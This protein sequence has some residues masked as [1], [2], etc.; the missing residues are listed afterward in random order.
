MQKI[1]LFLLLM[2]CVSFLRAQ[3]SPS[4]TGNNTYNYKSETMSVSG[5][6]G[7]GYLNTT[8]TLS[9]SG[10]EFHIGFPYRFV[11]TQDA[12]KGDL[13]VS[14]GYYSNYIRLQWEI[15]DPEVV[16]Q[17]KIYR[18]LL[19]EAD[20][21]FSLAATVSSQE[22][23]WQDQYAEPGLMYEYKVLADGI[24]DTEII[25]INRV[26]GVGFRVTSATIT[27]RVTYA[28]GNVVPGVKIIAEPE[29]ENKEGEFSYNFPG[30][31]YALV[32][33]ENQ[34]NL[35]EGAS[36]QAWVKPTIKE[37]QSDYPIFSIG[38]SLSLGIKHSD[39]NNFVQVQMG[40]DIKLSEAI[41]DSIFNEF[42]QLSLT[43]N[44]KSKECLI[45]LNGDSLLHSSF[46]SG[47]VA[48]ANWL[49][50]GSIK[51]ENYNYYSGYLDEVKLWSKTLSNK[52][53]FSTFDSYQNPNNASLAGYWKFNEGGGNNIY[54]ISRTGNNFN[55]NHGLIVKHGSEY[56]TYEE[57]YP[58]TER[59]GYKAVT[60]EN[61]NY[62]IAGVAFSSGG[63]YF[64][65]VPSLGVHRFDPTNKLL[66]ISQESSVF[67]NIDFTDE[68]SFTVTGKIFYK[69]TK[70]PVSDVY[71][72]V[73]GS[74]VSDSK[75]QPI[76]TDENGEYTIDVPIGLH[77]ISVEKNGHVFESAYWPAMDENENPTYFDF[78]DDLNGRDFSDTTKIKL[79]GKIVG[80]PIQG[81]KATG[82]K[83]E[84]TKANIGVVNVTLTTERGFEL[85]DDN[86]DVSFKTD[87]TT[88]VYE[89]ELIPEKFILKN[90][91]SV[92]N[93]HYTF[94]R[95]EDKTTID[96]SNKFTL[97]YTIDSVCVDSLVEDE[98][99]KFFD[100]VDT[101]LVYNHNRD[102][103]WRETPKL[104]VQ[105]SDKVAFWGDSVYTITNVDETTTD[106]KLVEFNETTEEYEYTFNYPIFK[107][108]QYYD[109]TVK[110]TETYIN[111]DD[112]EN[113]VYDNVPVTDGV[114]LV[115]NQLANSNKS[116]RIELNENGKAVHSFCGGMP[117]ESSPFTQNINFKLKINDAFITGADL[118]QACYL[119]GIKPSGGTNFVTG[120]DE[121]DFILRDPPGSNSYSYFE[122]GFT[123]SNTKTESHTNGF[124]GDVDVL[125]L[126]G[127]EL[128]TNVGGLGF[129]IQNKIES[130]NSIGA[131]TSNE[132]MWNKD[133][134]QTTSKTYQF[135]FSTS[136]D[137]A[138]VGSMGD[139]YFGHG[140]NIF[141]GAA[142]GVKIIPDDAGV[143]FDGQ[144]YSIG[145]KKS[146]YTG[147]SS[148][149]EF[150]YT[151]NHIENYLIPNLIELRNA[152]F[153]GVKYIS[154]LDEN[155]ERYGLS[156]DDPIFEGASVD[157]TDTFIDGVSYTFTPDGENY[158]DS[159]YFY[160]EIINN[161]KQQ[162]A[163]N[164]ELK[165]TAVSDDDPNNKHT[166]ISFDAGAIVESAVTTDTSDVFTSTYDWSIDAGVAAD[167]G[168]TVNGF[169]MKVS[170]TERYHKGGTSSN[171]TEETS[172]ETI[173]FV[174]AD[175][176]QGD[177]FSLD[178]KK[179]TWV[180]APV[181]VLRGGQSSCPFEGIEKT[182]YFE[183][184]EHV[185][186]N[187]TMQIE[188]PV[189][190]AEISTVTNVPENLAAVFTLKMSNVSEVGADGWYG[191][192]VDAASNPDGAV[193]K[194][195]GSNLTNG[196]SVLIPAGQ[197][198]SK[199]ITVE[200]GKAE[201]NDYENL[202]IIMHSLCQFDPTD[203]VDDIADTAT[204]SAYFIP[205]CTKV[206]LA[207]PLDQWTV[208]VENNNELPIKIDGYDV[209]H[210]TFEDFMFQY[211]PSESSSWI[212]VKTFVNHPIEEGDVD[213]IDIN[214][215]PTISYVWDMSSLQNRE[216]D[217]RVISHCIDGST[218]E[219]DVVSGIFDNKRPELFGTPQPADGILSSNDEIML[220]FDEDIQAGLISKANISVTGIENN[221]DLRDFDFLQHNASLHFDGISQNMT[222]AQDINLKYSPFTF[223][224]WAKRERTGK[225]CIIA[226]GDTQDGGLWI[227]FDD[228][229]HF[230]MTINGQDISTTE[231]F[232]TTDIYNH[233]ACVFNNNN[234]SGEIE[235]MLI[236]ASG[237][238]TAIATKILTSNY[239][240]NAPLSVGYCTYDDSA[241]K[242]NIHDLRIWN[243][244]STSSEV[245]ARR[246]TI[247][248]GYE[249]GLIGAWPMDDMQG[250]LAKDIA[251]SRHGQ[252]NATWHTNSKGFGLALNG[253]YAVLN[254]SQLELSSNADFTIE[255]WFKS[256]I[257]SSDEYIL[258]N[259]K[260]DGSDNSELKWA[261]VAS[262]DNTIKILNDGSE[263]I[264]SG[265]D[266]LDN[267]WHH[268]AM[269]I[270]RHGNMDVY[271]D[272]SSK[273]TTSS[274]NVTGF[275]GSKCVLGARYWLDVTVEHFDANFN[276]NIDEAR[277]WNG[278]R[279]QDLIQNY[280]H[281]SLR[282]N[283]FGLKAYYPFED[284]T[285]TDP[286]MSTSTGNNMTL[287]ENGIAGECT[288]IGSASFSD[289]TAA[290]KLTRPVSEI[291]FSFTTNGN[292]ILISPTIDA[293]R[294]E[295]TTLDIAVNSIY[296]L[297]GN[298][299]ESTAAWSA[300]VDKNQ[301]VWEKQSVTLST[302]P[303][304][305]L[306]FKM[307]IYNQSG[308]KEYWQIDNLPVWL[309][310]DMEQGTLDPLSSQ[311]I[312][313]SVNPAV[314]VGQYSHDIYL[315]GSMDF[316]ERCTINL[317][318]KDKEPEWSVNPSDYETSM[319]LIGKLKIAGEF[320]TDESDMVG[321]FINNECRGVAKVKYFSDQNIYLV[322][323]T[324]HGESDEVSQVNLRVWDASKG[325]LYTNINTSNSLQESFDLKFK[326]NDIIGLP[327]APTLIET[328][329][330][331]GIEIPIKAGWNWLSF[332]LVSDQLDNTNALLAGVC[333]ETDDEIKFNEDP[334]GQGI[335]DEY[336]SPYGW[337]GALST[338]GFD[339]S[340]MY[341]L[342][343]SYADTIQLSGNPVLTA[344][345]PISINQG[346]N[347]IGYTPQ[348]KMPVKSALAY[349]SP[350]QNDLVKSQS[351]FAMYDD[352]LG[353]IGSL[354]YMEPN[355][356]YMYYSAN[357]NS[358]TFVYP[359]ETLFTKSA[360]IN[361]G[362]QSGVSFVDL[363]YE[364]NMSALIEVYNTPVKN[365]A[366]SRLLAI[367]DGKI[368]GQ[369][370]P[371]IVG[372]KYI[373]P[374][375]IS[376]PSEDKALSFQLIDSDSESVFTAKEEDTYR[377]NEILGSVNN[378][379]A[380]TF[381][382]NADE[383]KPLL[384]APN[385]FD[386]FT[387]ITNIPSDVTKIVLY[388]IKGQI[389]RQWS[390]TESGEIL[391]DCTSYNKINVQSGIYL[392]KVYGINGYQQI[393]IVKL[394]N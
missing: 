131:S 35:S 345:Y 38:T 167:L 143:V 196:M 202:H 389:I 352:M 9:N 24:W 85:W 165:V 37:G 249:K 139:V 314:N 154:K 63:S 127:V 255:F 367:V 347:W 331:I 225:E 54:D 322:N 7:E 205:A 262:A 303:D 243:Q 162:L 150:V 266:C 93:D 324:V 263:F 141:Y 201:V 111:H 82:S 348:Y 336:V 28:G 236:V 110:A 340:N 383:E 323:L 213:V 228:Q 71:L 337:D 365:V 58:S 34:P 50:G 370:S 184:D 287:D 240:Q 338:N 360:K 75:K 372:G 121:V 290:I 256:G 275:G 244:S 98:F 341:K 206:N 385:P 278:A 260:A 281:H 362:S 218:Y 72:K 371:V 258:S 49:I 291:P 103:V 264:I 283:E 222:V 187:A 27:G 307:I 17:I 10:N 286:S 233:Y 163:L 295:N 327:S 3:K 8:K 178:V 86:T 113:I 293:S 48:N 378:P 204:I 95:D 288:F 105:N 26:D 67:N 382:A 69:G 29:I 238:E 81:A 1:F 100:H 147:K 53:V 392:L 19:S 257:P 276:G 217:L 270:N 353:W 231:T 364:H 250:S 94:N 279:S 284:I 302:S 39:N 220:S 339:V 277:I 45:Y 160:N 107:Q 20:K 176:D 254:T 62:V 42:M 379:Y 41:P 334:N 241:F 215:Q 373:Y 330:N 221:T 358:A 46:T 253:G 301:L 164:E 155:D 309:D 267:N 169:G 306:E 25:G 350:S 158:T 119:L 316:N 313:F 343:N 13:Q 363:S 214:N 124:G 388:D 115:E 22:N 294:I 310:A 51:G 356:G 114:V 190:N 166:N 224:F 109:L 102:W 182:K 223:E 317:S 87:A 332:N 259:G 268:M 394:K 312:T 381:P 76:K 197:T 101:A 212:T 368:V 65:V 349:H 148:G 369:V 173:G 137:P 90:D 123:T 31:L 79:V 346:W 52:D 122:K 232:S 171:E 70:F 126:F 84:P 282:G 274:E 315:N 43:W 386:E 393:K 261:I 174:L 55:E 192:F 21:E 80:G 30:N 151:Q 172:S 14:K 153:D 33:P 200:K 304:E 161:W 47:N 60:D 177:Y 191:I 112:P 265:G 342:K 299:M 91:L 229:D 179:D 132:F 134:T 271:I 117:L 390:N 319:T 329:A 216:Y 77:Y 120:P 374:L 305:H 149:T 320:S 207:E 92:K 118:A 96:L 108:L 6:V 355:A 18:R 73:D 4:I 159:I 252:V 344:A 272:G 144:G 15:Y 326:Q 296:D 146:V 351:K 116:Q 145:T 40:D 234:A 359:Q 357:V 125:H 135:N 289:E 11:Y 333:S 189:L 387:R 245:Q 298:R 59:L 23:S 193:V 376:G 170:V 66:Y 140:T 2:G 248:N 133:N 285:I 239:F 335:Y 318:V 142:T 88:G 175:E 269:S 273:L 44:G 227:G 208:N 128:T 136:E 246:Y 226:H 328:S 152:L 354:E 198:V 391:W 242:G 375:T 194:M 185:L 237:A 16:T 99:V 199:T 209:N 251:F 5:M 83:V 61:G 210:S 321:A 186:N 297:N 74:I 300:F 247:L 183:P 188:M 211:K 311:E 361:E 384:V 68:S 64:R 78:Q 57:V 106:I 377:P 97:Q 180:G 12:F 157:T 235:V 195:D 104:S 366:N 36:I 230:M 168:F 138:F 156:N 203:D 308:E 280:M 32:R 129:S 130:E 89:V 181:F 325:N 219:S 380:I 56:G 292:R